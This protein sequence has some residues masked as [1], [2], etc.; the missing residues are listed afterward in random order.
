MKR[1]LVV[2]AVLAI[3]CLPVSA[4]GALCYVTDFSYTLIR[5]SGENGVF[6][7]NTYEDDGTFAMGRLDSD[8][9]QNRTAWTADGWSALFAPETWSVTLH[10]DA[11][12]FCPYA[13]SHSESVICPYMDVALVTLINKKSGAVLENRYLYRPKTYILSGGGAPCWGKYG[14]VSPETI[15][16]DGKDTR[17]ALKNSDGKW[18]V[19]DTAEQ[20][21]L[22]DWMYDGMSAVYGEYVK[23]FNGSA[24]GRLD[25]SGATDTEF[26]YGAENGFSVTEELRAVENGYRVFNAD[27][28]PIS[29]IYDASA[30][31]YSYIADTHLLLITAKDGTK[32][33]LDLNGDTVSTFT[34][35]QKAVY[36]SG[37]C[38][39]VEQYADS[40][41]I[42]GV[43]LA[44]VQD[45]PQPNDTVMRGDVNMDG[46]ADSTDARHM[47]DYTVDLQTFTARQR[48]AADVMMDD[49][50]DTR[51]IRAVII[52]R[53]E[54]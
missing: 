53:I 14:F 43:A 50:I 3:L 52:E 37:A 4:Q 21:M 54:Q 15:K 18:G 46:V 47:L 1:M 20:V 38:F 35:R 19:Y 44:K 5:D 8:G 29:V 16:W 7:F 31:T 28:E 39:A 2:L 25:L 42:D 23:V 11:A 49:T 51:D 33:L 41:A 22:T 17:V 45:V 26:K 48:L 40:G 6:L 27:N 30:A 13:A 36:L 24:W 32:T 12:S 34:N 9:E 10:G